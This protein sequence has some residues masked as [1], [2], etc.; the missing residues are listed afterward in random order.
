V[1]FLLY[2]IFSGFKPTQ[3]IIG[4]D[5]RYSNSRFQMAVWFFVLITTYIA[6]LWIRVLWAGWDFIGGV[7][8]PKNLLL[9]SGMSAL[10]FGGAKGIT[11][12][13][14]TAP[15]PAGAAEGRRP[16]HRW[17]RHHHGLDR[18]KNSSQSKGR[19]NG[20]IH[21]GQADDL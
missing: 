10:T 8:I 5:N 3:L 1:C 2:F 15:P 9:L 17:G 21:V 20:R 16:V 19:E 14:N 7:D 11:T 13:K 4:E 18:E 6:A 12:S